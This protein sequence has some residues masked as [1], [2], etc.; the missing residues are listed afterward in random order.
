MSAE[1][2]TAKRWKRERNY[3]H[4]MILLQDGPRSRIVNTWSEMATFGP[5]K[6]MDKWK[7]LGPQYMGNIPQNEGFGFPW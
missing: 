3:M 1:K 7:V 5:Q 6:P 4:G 2:S